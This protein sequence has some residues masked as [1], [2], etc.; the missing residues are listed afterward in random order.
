MESKSSHI[1]ISIKDEA[2][3]YPFIVNFNRINH[4]TEGRIDCILWNLVDLFTVCNRVNLALQRFRLQANR[5]FAGVYNGNGERGKSG[6]NKVFRV[7]RVV[8]LVKESVR[9][10]NF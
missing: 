4:K 5:V 9:S 1:L 6:F 3:I 8:D 2:E 7:V 10:N